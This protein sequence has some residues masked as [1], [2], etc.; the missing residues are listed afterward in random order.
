MKKYITVFIVCALFIF[1]SIRLTLLS[2][3]VAFNSDEISWFYHTEFFNQLFVK[4][5][6]NRQFWTTYESYD[7]PQLSKYIFGGY[8]FLQDKNIFTKRDILEQRWGRWNFYFDKNL[9]DISS[10]EF[11]QYIIKMREV[12][13]PF[14]VGS[15]IFIFLCLSLSTGN[16]YIASFIPVLL[17]F[18]SLFITTMLRATSD[19]QMIFFVLL[20]VWIMCMDFAKKNFPLLLSFGFAVGCAVSVKLTGMIMFAVFVVYEYILIF[21]HKMK[22]ID[23]L[24]RFA[25]ILVTAGFVWFFF[26]PALYGDFYGGTGE[27][28]SFRLKQSV[29]LE[30]YFNDVALKDTKSRTVATFCSLF[31]PSCARHDGAMTPNVYINSVLFCIGFAVFLKKCRNTFALWTVFI[32]IICVLIVNTAYIPLDS[33]RYYLLPV[34]VMYMVYAAGFEEIW[35]V[36]RK[37]LGKKT[38]NPA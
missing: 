30:R 9:S 28:I 17:L 16:I 8:L 2:P 3:Q 29:K 38:K 21:L 13:I 7:H 12:N 26:N 34:V 14:A 18:N 6:L 35:N 15:L 31:N 19:A 36:L 33:D 27:Y 1:A 11:A 4:H 24:K 32:F 5:N 10:T 22:I 37:V 20:S 25:T 23:F